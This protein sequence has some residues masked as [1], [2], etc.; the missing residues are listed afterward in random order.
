MSEQKTA[1]WMRLH[2][3]AY[4]AISV[5]YSGKAAK[6]TKVPYLNHIDEGLLVM[7]Y[8]GCS[9]DEMDAFCIH[10]LVQ[11][12]A[13]L[14]NCMEPNSYEQRLLRCGADNVRVM[15]FAMEYRRSANSYLSY[16]KPE[17]LVMSPLQEVRQM[18]IADKVQNRKDFEL[19][20]VN[21]RDDVPR[22]PR[23][24]ELAEYF[25]NWC[26]I[27]GVSEEDYERY[28]YLIEEDKKARGVV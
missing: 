8:L 6:R 14:E 25:D 10:P 15:V 28:C 24:K 3:H 7:Q 21:Q 5:H 1:S 2:S 11:D 27:L 17:D 22:H 18:L 9:Q 20:Y 16:D 4:H 26:R 12:D 19:Y 13:A 23:Q